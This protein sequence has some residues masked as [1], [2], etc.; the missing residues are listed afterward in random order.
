MPLRGPRRERKVK[1]RITAAP[2]PFLKQTA[3]RTGA[4][5]GGEPESGFRGLHQHDDSGGSAGGANPSGGN[6]KPPAGRRPNHPATTGEPTF[7]EERTPAPFPPTSN[8]RRC[9]LLI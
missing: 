5:C 7:L 3:E 4:A 6:E 8:K 9:R 1:L 2:T